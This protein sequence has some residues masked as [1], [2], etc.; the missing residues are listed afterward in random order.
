MAYIFE[1]LNEQGQPVATAVSEADA[2]VRDSFVALIAKFAHDF[3]P[4]D[5]NTS[6]SPLAFSSDSDS[7]IRIGETI[8]VD[9]NFRFVENY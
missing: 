4:L 9:K 8:T 1:P 7:F 2:K 5:N 6:E 3:T